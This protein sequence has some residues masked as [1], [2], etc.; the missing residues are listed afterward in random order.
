MHARDE[1]GKQAKI[2]Y[3]I[4]LLLREKDSGPHA[5]WPRQL[6]LSTNES[7]ESVHVEG[8]NVRAVTWVKVW[9]RMVQWRHEGVPT[10]RT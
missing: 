3:S 7:A 10:K 8:G 1:G 2:S 5:V 4:A 9:H 6:D